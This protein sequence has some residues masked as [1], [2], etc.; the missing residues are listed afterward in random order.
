MGLADASILQGI[1][2]GSEKFSAF[3]RKLGGT[4]A[5]S[6]LSATIQ[7]VTDAGKNPFPEHGL[8]R[9]LFGGIKIP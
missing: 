3:C 9:E 7:I 8:V 5:R 6:A 4:M 1:T 2:Y